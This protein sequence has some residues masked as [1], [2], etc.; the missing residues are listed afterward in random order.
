MKRWEAAGMVLSEGNNKIH[1]P[2]PLKITNYHIIFLFNWYK[3]VCAGLFLSQLLPRA[4]RLQENCFYKRIGDLNCFEMC[5]S[6]FGKNILNGMFAEFITSMWGY[7]ELKG[8]KLWTERVCCLCSN[9]RLPTRLC[10]EILR[11]VISSLV[12]CQTSALFDRVWGNLLIERIR[13][14]VLISLV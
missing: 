13:W 11:G 8:L 3:N 7:F 10:E 2:A 6:V 1:L 4:L 5:I 14:W 12:G 9:H